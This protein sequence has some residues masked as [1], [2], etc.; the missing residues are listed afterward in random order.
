[1]KLPFLLLMLPSHLR[2]SP[3]TAFGN[4]NVIVPSG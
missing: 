3:R 4:A 1:M 2:E